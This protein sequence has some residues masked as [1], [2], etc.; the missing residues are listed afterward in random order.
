[1]VFAVLLLRTKFNYNDLPTPNIYPCNHVL[2][3][4]L[5]VIKWDVLKTI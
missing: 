2:K 3:K 5:K 4:V 1:M